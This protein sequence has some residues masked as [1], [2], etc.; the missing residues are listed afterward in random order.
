VAKVADYD[1]AA[2]DE[3]IAA[4]RWYA[5]R[6]VDVALAFVAEVQAVI[7]RASAF[8]LSYAEHIAGTRRAVLKRFPYAVIYRD[9]PSRLLVVAVAHQ[10]RKPG[11][12]RSR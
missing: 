8:P 12:W 10:R 7:A 11:Y 4:T 1:R 5:E 6:D 9:E 2:R 3:V